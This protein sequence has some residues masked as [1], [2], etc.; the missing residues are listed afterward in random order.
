MKI[1]NLVLALMFLV[2]AFLQV[3]DPD[4]FVWILIYGSMAVICVMAS[5]RYYP[6]IFIIIV[7]VIFAGYSFMFL[8]GVKEWLGQDDKTALFDNVAKMEHIYIEESREYLGLLICLVVL[9]I[10]LWFSWRP[11]KTSGH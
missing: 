8:P 6:K 10:Q 7:F 3:N 11:A 1:V 4:P 9:S 2:F 5:F